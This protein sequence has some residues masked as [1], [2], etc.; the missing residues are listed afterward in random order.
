MDTQL[1]PPLPFFLILDFFD[2]T[3]T[4]YKIK[5][6]NLDDTNNVL[7]LLI[8]FKFNQMF[9]FWKLTL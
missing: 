9:S 4:F 1:L 5:T 2:Q 6:I 7:S 8:Y 3:N